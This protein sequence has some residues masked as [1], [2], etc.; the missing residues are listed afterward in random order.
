MFVIEYL[1]IRKVFVI[2][3]LLFMSFISFVYGQGET[4]NWYF[5][6]NAGINFNDDGSVTVLNDG[7]LNTQEGAGS[8]SDSDGNLLFYTDGSIVYN[9]D[10][11]IMQNGADLLGTASSSQSALII[12]WPSNP[13]LYFLVTTNTR[14]L[15]V[16]ALGGLNYS[17][18]DMS[19]NNGLGAVTIKNQN[20][21]D[22]GSEKITAVA[23]DC[24]SNSFWLLSFSASGGA[25]RPF[26]AFYAFEIDDTGLN[27]TP[28]ISA[29]PTLNIR[30]E[31]GYMKF[32]PDGEFL[33]SANMRDGLYFY[34]FDKTTGQLSNQEQII[35]QAGR[36][37]FPY[38]VE[39]SPDSNL[40]YVTSSNDVSTFDNSSTLMQFDITAN[41]IGASQIT[42]D[43]NLLYRSGLQLGRNGKIY[44]ALSR[45]SIVGI[46][47]LAAINEPNERGLSCDYEEE[48]VNLE[49][50][51]AS[52]GLP[53]YVQSYFRRNQ[54]FENNVGLP[55]ESLTFCEGESFDVEAEVVA[56][57]LYSWTMN[58]VPIPSQN[59]NRLVVNNLR[60]EDSGIYQVTIND[61][62]GL[63]CTLNGEVEV[64]VAQQS[65]LTPLDLLVCDIDGI[66][67]DGLAT[68]NLNNLPLNASGNYTFFASLEEMTAGNSISDITNFRNTVPYN[69][70]IFY[71]YEND[72]GC[73][74]SSEVNLSVTLD[75]TLSLDSEYFLCFPND[76]LN[77]SLEQ[78]FST[79][80]W[81]KIIGD[82]EVLISDDATVEIAESGSYRI[83]LNGE[84]LENGMISS[85]EYIFAF[86]VL[87]A[88]EPVIDDI[89]VTPQNEIEVLVSNIADY[90]FSINGGS[91]QSS[92]IFTDF[93]QGNN[94]IVIRNSENCGI[95]ETEF[96]M[97]N[98]FS[99]N[100]FPNFFTPNGDG[101]NDIWQI[102]TSNNNLNDIERI[103]I[104]DRQ[105]KL[106]FVFTPEELGWNGEINNRPAIE[107]DYWFIVDM[108][109][110][111]SITGHFS[112]KR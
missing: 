6:F 4:D 38:G 18:I 100:D 35:F 84:I 2:F 92:N 66:S 48:A 52:Q 53:S 111:K 34:D 43:D 88:D 63:F 30:D 28:V 107:T 71:Q 40:L 60:I 108:A 67:S 45:T 9:R 61:S 57:G 24:D 80:N 42:I 86:E 75:P 47:F 49:S 101:I 103:S 90:Q 93:I 105:G 50:G 73:I 58:G 15:F 41:N 64:L 29:F 94:I 31:R 37:N 1:D 76:V 14:S 102:S 89:R 97:T 55:R 5:G 17:V 8:I 16:P 85:C 95:L 27:T 74:S 36:N 51:L 70:I 21:L 59:T 65:A 91:F 23:S 68:F 82:E 99:N 62:N 7:Q 110:K 78:E 72:S 54:V 33:V 109:N 22:D 104:F 39:F 13:N 87:M 83:T 96:D 44:R 32:S 77:L 81:Y 69:Q 3:I 19:L 11:N 56:G 12:P 79:Y 112:L 25:R 10:H 20:L 98:Q 26:D 46:E 106:I